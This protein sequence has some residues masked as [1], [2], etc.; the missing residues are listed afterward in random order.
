M[1][2]DENFLMLEKKNEHVFISYFVVVVE[3]PMSLRLKK[4]IFI[5]PIICLNH[6]DFRVQKLVHYLINTV[7]N[8]SKN[9]FPFYTWYIRPIVKGCRKKCYVQLH[10]LWINPQRLIHFK[11]LD[12]PARSIY[13]G[14][15]QVKKDNPCMLITTTTWRVFSK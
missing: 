5:L 2:F 13:H 11:L 7:T 6:F 9:I 10:L 3:Y 8:I 1:A 15:A 4:R 14:F 12:S